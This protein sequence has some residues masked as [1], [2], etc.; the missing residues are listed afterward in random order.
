MADKMKSIPDTVKN[1]PALAI[2]VVVSSDT[3]SKFKDGDDVNIKVKQRVS[4]S[5]L[6]NRVVWKTFLQY[7]DGT[8]LVDVQFEE[9]KYNKE[10]T[11]LPRESQ[12]LTEKVTEVNKPC[13][14]QQL[15]KINT[16]TVNTQA[17]KKTEPETSITFHMNSEKLI[18]LKDGDKVMFVDRLG[19]KLA[20]KTKECVDK[21]KEIIAYIRELNKSGK[22][23]YFTIVLYFDFNSYEGWV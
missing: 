13:Q 9:N 17:E 12:T 4:A 2:R 18:S 3:S 7:D 8:L 15:E 19:N 1:T 21:S 23:N 20:V 5:H 16:E 22:F 11:E 14:T 10:A 6:W